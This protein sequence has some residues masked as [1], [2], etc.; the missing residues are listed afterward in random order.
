MIK[1][2]EKAYTLPL[3]EPTWSVSAYYER[4][5]E[6]LIEILSRQKPVDQ[7]ITLWWGLDGLR[8][9]ED[10]SLEWISKKKPEPEPQ[11]VN[12]NVFYQPCQSVLCANNR[13]SAMGNMC[14]SPQSVLAALSA[15]NTALQIQ[16][17]QQ[18][19]IGVLPIQSTVFMS[20]LQNCYGHPYYGKGW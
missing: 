20:P 18:C 11:P 19:A 15:Q 12:Q 13:I 7:T 6:A 17:A 16:A 4:M 2:T 5:E 10:G 8:L 9:N 14:Q 3:K 1:L